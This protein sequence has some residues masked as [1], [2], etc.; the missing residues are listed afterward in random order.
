MQNLLSKLKK[1]TDQLLQLEEHITPHWGIMTPHHMIEH[2]GMIVYGTAQ[3]KGQSLVIPEEESVK[4]KNRFFSSYYPF[5][6]NIPMA[7]TQK[8]L[9]TQRDLRYSSI[10][11]AKEKLKG[12][13]HLFSKKMAEDPNLGAVHGYF[14][15]LT[16]EEWLAFHIK[17]MEHH[18]M[19]FG[20]IDFDDKIPAMEKM[21][22]ELN[23]N[24]TKDTPSKFGKMDAHQMI[25]HVGMVFLLST[26]K[27]DFPYKGTEEDAQTYQGNFV[28]SDRPWE[29]VFPQASFGDPRPPRHEKIEDSKREL[30]KTFSR[31]LTYCEEHPDAIHPH[32]YLGNITI[33]MWRQVH[34]KHLE[35]HMRQFGFDV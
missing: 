30:R 19:Q 31:Y 6:R 4:W 21:L 10:E 33:D 26:G 32:F 14:G 7:G 8:K 3:G 15:H 13:V 11:E 35:H 27:F 2:L 29:D 23:K 28:K 22:Y 17:H 9:V 5:P 18:L 16:G 1:R 25:E 12:A 24:V 20:Q 34:V